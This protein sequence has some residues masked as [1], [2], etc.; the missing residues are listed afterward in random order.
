MMQMPE[1]PIGLSS[2][3]L[4]VAA[5]LTRRQLKVP[6]YQRRYTWGEREVRQL[7]RDLWSAF[8]RRATFYFIG[9]IVLVKNLGKHEVS[10]GQQRLT[11]L[12]MILAY[13]RDRLPAR[14]AQ[15]Q[16]FVLEGDQPRLLLRDDDAN[17]FRGYVQEP[18]H[19]SALA[20]H[21]ET[22]SESKDQLCIAARTIA[23]ELT[24]L[25]NEELEAFISYGLRACTLN[26]VDAD[27]RGCAQTVFAAL[28][29][30]GS[31]L[32]GADVIKS[33]LLENAG[34]SSD[35][36]DQAADA[37]ETIE[38]MFSRED[39][40]R[41]LDLMPFLLTGE[42]ILSPGDLMAFRNAIDRAGGARKFLFEW[43]PRYADALRAIL[44]CAIDVGPA[45]ADVNRRVHLL[46][47]IEQWD[48]APA[49]I[50]YLAQYADHR[51]HERAQ[52][53]FQTLDRFAFASELSAIDNRSQSKR[54][55]RAVAAIRKG[56][57]ECDALALSESEQQQLFGAINR[58]RKRDRQRRLLLIRV[59]AALPGGSLLSMTDDTTVEHIMP[60]G[61]APWWD[62]RFPDAERRKEW[63]NM[64]GNETLIT[65][66]QNRRADRNSYPIKRDIFLNTLGAPVHAL[67]RMLA[68]I[69]E[70]TLA[71]ID[72][73]HNRLVRALC[74]DWGIIGAED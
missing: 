68:D 46:K 60:K 44:W 16:V 47:Q 73:R 41:L 19:M 30:R 7:I 8:E 36:A 43:F 50:A 29:I 59:E 24:Q 18:G 9:Q 40:A 22:G 33:D 31:P 21:G 13:A 5:V 66:D 38:D 70:W 64:I 55:E 69:D 26:V 32:S 4:N 51:D 48:W 54:Y 37:W 15:F 25:S 65:H 12:S 39:F 1:T 27:E 28:N 2:Q 35:E 71:E 11:T 57:G 42:H 63:C 20:L 10:D 53:F 58:A 23:A 61:N 34:L 56:H 6:R 14:A 67:S 74:V 52:L 45:S 49:A 62:A 17:F 3:V 72:L